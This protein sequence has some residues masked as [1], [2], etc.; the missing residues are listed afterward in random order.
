MHDPSE[1]DVGREHCVDVAV[2]GE[3]AHAVGS[4]MVDRGGV[5]Y[6]ELPTLAIWL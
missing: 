3:N 4:Q 2:A 1:A 6:S 5:F